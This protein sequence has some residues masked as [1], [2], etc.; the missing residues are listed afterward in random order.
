MA[1]KV[2]VYFRNS[3]LKLDENQVSMS[4]KKF[5]VATYL[6]WNKATRDQ[7]YN[8]DFAIKQLP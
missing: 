8:T 5:S 4:L 7:Y 1:S 2:A 3:Y 6:P